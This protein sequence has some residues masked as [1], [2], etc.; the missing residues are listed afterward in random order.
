[1]IL[2]ALRS[3]QSGLNPN[4][5]TSCGISPFWFYKMV[6]AERIELPMLLERLGYGQMDAIVRYAQNG[7]SPE[8]STLILFRST[9]FQDESPKRRQ[10]DPKL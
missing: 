2:G 1:M 8:G 4:K 5:Y 7:G 6:R 10:D 3:H 9:R